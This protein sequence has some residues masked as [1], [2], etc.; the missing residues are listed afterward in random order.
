MAMPSLRDGVFL[1]LIDEANLCISGEILKTERSTRHGLF[2]VQVSQE[3]C[4]NG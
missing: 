2:R 3:A 4:G 1:N